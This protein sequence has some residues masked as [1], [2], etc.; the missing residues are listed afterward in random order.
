MLLIKTLCSISSSS[1]QYFL[2]NFSPSIRLSTM[3][4]DFTCHLLNSVH[5][6]MDGKKIPELW[7]VYKDAPGL[8]W[9]DAV[10]VLRTKK[11]KHF[12]I[13]SM[14]LKQALIVSVMIRANLPRIFIGLS[15][16]N[17]AYIF[18]S[19]CINRVFAKRL[20][21]SCSFWISQ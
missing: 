3:Y 21:S 20:Y 8:D 12:K 11:H 18:P 10:R 13:L 9:N 15:E 19:I 16:H 1:K 5:Y 6:L 2:K 7:T 17:G 4:R 14:L